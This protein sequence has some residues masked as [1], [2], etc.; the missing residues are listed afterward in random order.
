[1]AS[2]SFSPL[3]A[4]S[5]CEPVIVKVLTGQL[6]SP[7]S[8]KAVEDV[9]RGFFYQLTLESVTQENL[10][11]PEEQLDSNKKIL[12]IF[13]GARSIE[14]WR[15]PKE[16]EKLINRLLTEGR[17]RIFGIC[18]GGYFSSAKIIYNEK[19]KELFHDLHFF[20]GSCIGPVVPKDKEEE[21]VSIV[22]LKVEGSIVPSVEIKCGYFKPSEDLERRR[23]YKV[24]A[25]YAGEN[26]IAAIACKPLLCKSSKTW[27]YGVVLVGPHLEMSLLTHSKKL[28]EMGLKEDHIERLEQSRL[29][30]LSLIFKTMGFK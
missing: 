15:F 20:N 16:I 10:N 14:E 24:I 26:K 12:L 13:P 28:L 27:C 22:V 9:V 21:E 6:V 4:P 29:K 19:E 3:I 17:I 11:F 25:T 30:T 18:A 23:E 1:M 7:E 5:F 2:V 8:S